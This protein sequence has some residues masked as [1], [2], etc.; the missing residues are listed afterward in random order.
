MAFYDCQDGI[1]FKKGGHDDSS[2]KEV[3]TIGLNGF[4]LNDK[5]FIE[6][7]N[8]EKVIF[9]ADAIKTYEYQTEFKNNVR[10]NLVSTG[11]NVE[12]T[13]AQ[14]GGLQ[15]TG[16]NSIWSIDNNNEINLSK[17]IIKAKTKTFNVLHNLSFGE[18]TMQY[19]EVV[20][21]NK[22]VGYDLYVN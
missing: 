16:T 7:E 2:A 21:S 6:I 15:F 20:K 19:K 9:N 22:I 13:T 14:Y 3:F 8:D 12:S 17:N 11:I 10:A 18:N 1:V 4:K 5:L